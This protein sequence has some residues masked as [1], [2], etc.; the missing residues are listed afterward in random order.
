MNKTS[1]NKSTEIIEEKT[2]AVHLGTRRWENSREK[3]EMF[4]VIYDFR[5]ILWFTYHITY[6]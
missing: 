6:F 4:I 5:N 2:T 3:T 1:K